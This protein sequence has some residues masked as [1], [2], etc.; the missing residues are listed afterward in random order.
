MC[1][2]FHCRDLGTVV[3]MVW[4]IVGK[5]MRKCVDKRGELY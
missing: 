3:F 1:F 5:I 4:R 2:D